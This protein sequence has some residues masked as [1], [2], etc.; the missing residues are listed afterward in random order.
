ML[1]HGHEEQDL[2]TLHKE[3]DEID[4]ELSD[5]FSDT[6][7]TWGITVGRMHITRRIS[8]QGWF[9]IFIGTCV[10]SFAAGAP[11]SILEPTREL[12]F[13]MVVGSI[14][15]GASLLTQAWA[16]QVQAERE[17]G[18]RMFGQGQQ[19]HVRQLMRRREQILDEIDRRNELELH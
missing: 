14:F 8:S 2:P 7:H 19:R 6:T 1:E 4:I 16:L 11:L 18:R 13:A 12:G 10:G 3:L 15:A 5:I 17:T 9:K